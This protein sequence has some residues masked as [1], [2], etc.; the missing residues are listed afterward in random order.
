VAGDREL[1]TRTAE[2]VEQL[3]LKEAGRR[4]AAALVADVGSMRCRLAG[5]VER[6]AK[7]SVK[8]SKGGL[9]DIHFII[10]LL[11]LR[12]GV[13]SPDDKDTV[14]LLTH[15]NRLGRL[16]DEAMRVLYES[17]LFFRALDHEM[18]LI[19]DRPLA[20]LPEDPARLSEIALAFEGAPADPLV[21][22]RRLKDAFQSHAAAVRRVYEEIVR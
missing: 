21:R 10:E 3:I 9:F 5:A 19:Y 7:T 8:L 1:G 6:E 13:R 14:R 18:R 16:G 17:Y 11:Q 20:D 2:A 4:G 12:H 15:L 22:A